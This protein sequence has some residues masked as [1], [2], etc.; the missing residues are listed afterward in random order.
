MDFMIWAARVSHL[1][2]VIV[3]L[4]TLLYQGAVI[5]PLW[6][7]G[8]QGKDDRVEQALV[9]GAPFL[10]MGLTTVFVTGVLLMLFSTRF[11]LFSYHDWWSVA[12]GLKQIAFLFM[13]FFTIGLARLTAGFREILDTQGASMA[14]V[15]RNRIVQFNRYSIVFGIAALLLASSMR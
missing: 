14:G 11:V 2:G 9:K 12:L 4:G 3:W 15:L 8:Q 6:L 13:A 7:S 1:F 5:L 10:W